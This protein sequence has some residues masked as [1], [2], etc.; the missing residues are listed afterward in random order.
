MSWKGKT[1]R[2]VPGGVTVRNL[3]RGLSW[4]WNT[5]TLST[6]QRS[7]G[8]MPQ[9][10]SPGMQTRALPQ[11]AAPQSLLMTAALGIWLACFCSYRNQITI[12]RIL[13]FASVKEKKKDESMTKCSKTL[14]L[15]CCFSPSPLAILPARQKHMHRDTQ[16]QTHRK[17]ELDQ[18]SSQ[19]SRGPPSSAVGTWD[20]TVLNQRSK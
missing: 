2:C 10:L 14:W 5:T 7:W 9:A 13:A 16:M 20:P 12:H 6:P 17:P 1:M 19:D 8:W 11:H 15:F 18:E 4:L 3:W